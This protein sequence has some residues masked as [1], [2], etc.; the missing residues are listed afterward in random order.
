MSNLIQWCK[1]VINICNNNQGFI[2]AILTVMTIFI[3]VIAIIT[4]NRIGKIPYKKKINAIPSIY[5]ENGS[6]IID[7]MIINHGLMT[8]VIRDIAVRD[9]KKSYV[10][11]THIMEPIVLMPAE[12]KIISISISDHNGLIEKYAIDLN[13]KITIEVHEYGGIVHKFKKGF[14]VG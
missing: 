6:W 12:C 3:S 1:D 8:L 4:S 14:P 9:A 11:G 2:S 10:G 5:K 13:N 7:V